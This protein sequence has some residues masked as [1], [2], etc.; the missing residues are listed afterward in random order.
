MS[1]NVASANAFKQY[2]ISDSGVVVSASNIERQA[3]QHGT[4]ISSIDS[5]TM[6]NGE[7]YYPINEMGV[8][9][10]SYTFADKDRIDIVTDITPVSTTQSTTVYHTVELTIITDSGRVNRELTSDQ[11]HSVNPAEKPHEFFKSTYK[12]SEKHAEKLEEYAGYNPYLVSPEEILPLLTHDDASVQRSAIAALRHIIS[13]RGSECVHTL[14][15]LK[16]VLETSSA[17]PIVRDA[18]YCVLQIGQLHPREVVI[19]ADILTN[20]QISLNK[21]IREYALRISII[22][23]SIEPPPYASITE[24]LTQSQSGTETDRVLIAEL[25]NIVS[26]H[27]PEPFI[28]HVE[29]IIKINNT[30]TV[31]ETTIAL[32][33]VLSHIASYNPDVILGSLDS[34]V[35]QLESD[36]PNTQGNAISTLYHVSA[37]YPDTVIEHIDVIRTIFTPTNEIVLINTTALLSRLASYNPDSV[38]N[39]TDLLVEALHTDTEQAQINAATA[40]QHFTTLSESEREQVTNI[41]STINVNSHSVNTE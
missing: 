29:H 41:L 19:F 17:T 23:G 39:T 6:I 5:A 18:L 8:Y 36:S 10:F 24:L 38:S 14:R 12:S 28:P 9:T 2:F 20:H 1:S 35:K 27:T 4:P 25:L 11:I 16:S 30:A 15:Q 33:G 26:S 40:L 13:T 32:S 37:A 7:T 3:L 22:I 21:Y 34:I 31:T